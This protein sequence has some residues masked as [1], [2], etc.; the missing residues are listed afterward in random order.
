MPTTHDETSGGALG[1]ALQSWLSPWPDE[2]V[3]HQSPQLLVVDKPCGLPV[4][5]GPEGLGDDVVTRLAA[6]LEARGE[7]SYLGVHQRLDKDTSGVLFFVRDHAL[8]PAV[9]EEMEAHRSRRVYVACVSAPPGETPAIGEWVLM[10]DQLLTRKA[11]QGLTT[12]VVKAGGKLARARYRV[13]EAQG[14]RAL[15]EIHPETGRTHQLRVQLASRGLPIV[16]DSIYGGWQAERLML[17]CAELGLS[18]VELRVEAPLPAEF[19]LWLAR[20]EQH[21]PRGAAADSQGEISFDP[22][23]E[24]ERLQRKLREAVG[25]RWPLK[26]QT[27][28]LRL[29][30]EQGDGLA[31]VSCDA[32]ADWAVLSVY[33]SDAQRRSGE[34]ADWLIELGFRGVYLKQ[35]VKADL[36]HQDQEQLAPAAVFRGEAAPP[37]LVVSEGSM[38]LVVRL[39]DGLSTGLFIDQRDNRARVLATSRGQRVLNLFSYS[40]SFTVAAALGGAAETVSV[41]LSA[42][43]LSWCEQNLKENQLAGPQHRLLRADAAD[44]L[45]RARRREERFDLIILDP[46]SFGSHG[47]RSFS[48]ARDYP[49]LATDAAALLAPGG[50]LLAVTNHRKTGAERFRRWLTDAAKAAKCPLESARAG[51]P[52]LDCPAWS[53]GSPTKAVWLQRR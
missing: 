53:E 48:V 2:R 13:L 27:Q 31:G 33:S 40:G 42:R 26:A 24:G 38:R 7:A 49:A 20:Q 52:P 16:G 44:Y 15:I 37:E 46:P 17:H 14:R 19:G 29:V 39:D 43:M 1:S 36:R 6:W 9:S 50:R 21:K 32:Y 12:Q 41:D 5:G 51:K 22:L 4:H 25:R 3:L 45:R 35:R 34:L 18:C 8:N 11:S 28:A 30:H 10:E 23:P 47:K